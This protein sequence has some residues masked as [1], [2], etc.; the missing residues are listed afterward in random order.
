MPAWFLPE[1]DTHEPHSICICFIRINQLN[2]ERFFIF[3][4][5]SQ[6]L[7]ISQLSNDSRPCLAV[8]SRDLSR[9]L[10]DASGCLRCSMNRERF[11]ISYII[12]DGYIKLS[13]NE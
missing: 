13:R 11:V 9:E 5:Y 12:I 1:I 6:H 3:R 8:I 2:Y 4:V 7:C 10:T